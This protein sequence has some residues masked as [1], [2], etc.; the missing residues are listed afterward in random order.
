M[1]PRTHMLW[2][3]LM[4]NPVPLHTDVV[5]G[6]QHMLHVILLGN[7]TINRVN[8]ALRPGPVSYGYDPPENWE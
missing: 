2:V 4:C 7:N 1:T 3:V 6:T 5:S 8:R